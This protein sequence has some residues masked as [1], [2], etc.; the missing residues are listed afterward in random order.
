ME[1]ISLGR[2]PDN[3]NYNLVVGLES[4]ADSQISR[5]RSCYSEFPKMIENRVQSS[6]SLLEAGRLSIEDLWLSLPDLPW[7]QLGLY[8]QPIA[9]ALSNQYLKIKIDRL[10]ALVGNGKDSQEGCSTSVTYHTGRIHQLPVDGRMQDVYMTIQTQYSSPSL[11]HHD[12]FQPPHPTLQASSRK[13]FQSDWHLTGVRSV[14]SGRFDSL[15]DF[16][17]RLV[18]TLWSV[19][20]DDA[21][22]MPLEEVS[23]SLQTRY[24]VEPEKSSPG[25][26]SRIFTRLN[27]RDFEQLKR[28]AFKNPHTSAE[29]TAYIAL[30]SNV[31]NRIASIESACKSMETRGVK[32][33]RTSA[34]YETA[35]MY[36]E[37]QQ[38]FINGV[39]QVR[40]FR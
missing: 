1:S 6:S 21:L 3:L 5:A 26:Q 27:R 11:H 23:V 29:H 22:A 13:D 18:L 24:P 33:V 15:Q 36:Y 38:P 28:S 4:T 32:I 10:S 30:G 8:P 2:L 17:H 39:C 12:P 35:P 7:T 31:D 37:N 34:L 16:A 9:S 19:N 20:E 25:T 40:Q 14:L